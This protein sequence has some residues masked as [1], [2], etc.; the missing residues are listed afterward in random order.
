MQSAYQTINRSLQQ[1]AV[2]A[3][4]LAQLPNILQDMSAQPGA[5]ACRVCSALHLST[6]FCTRHANVCSA[7]RKTLKRLQCSAKTRRD[8]TKGD[9]RVTCRSAA[10]AWAFWMVERASAW[11]AARCCSACCLTPSISPCMPAS[12]QTDRHTNRQLTI[13]ERECLSNV[14]Q[15]AASSP[16]CHPTRH[17][18]L[19]QTDRQAVD[20]L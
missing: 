8:C 12:T 14:V 5:L 1:Q 20:H 15:P 17:L 4:L 3:V 19:R 16:P 9:R 7:L 6:V 13:S 2:H 10:V 18:T 11:T